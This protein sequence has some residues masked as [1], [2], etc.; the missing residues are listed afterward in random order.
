MMPHKIYAITR[1]EDAN[2]IPRYTAPQS[3]PVS[4][5][6]SPQTAFLMH[7]LLQSALRKGTGEHGIDHLNPD[8]STAGKTGTTYD[9]ADNWF[10]GYN[11]RV[12]CA[13]WAG[14][15]HGRRDAIYPAAFSR[16][17]VLP[18]W[19]ETM[20]AAHS[21][22]PGKLIQ[23]PEGIVKLDICKDSALRK[24]RYC[25]NYKR[26]VRTGI[27][28]YVSTAYTEYFLKG[29]APS[30]FCDVHGVS[31]PSLAQAD[32]NMGSSRNMTT[33]AIPVQPRAPTLL[34]NDPYG[35]EQP[36]F[37]PRDEVALRRNRTSL[38]FDQLES[39]DRAAAIVLDKPQ[40]VE[41]LED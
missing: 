11:S 19:V 28:S 23:A 16:E 37:A 17:T 35:T 4:R 22:F 6:V 8:P 36:D 12:T 26:N 24:T 1:I 39:E 18:V 32:L 29:A 27:E 13:V 3:S 34:G 14:F 15:L 5:V 25:Q 7:S 2:G 21:L 31:D 38:N 40:R 41:I 33:H 20:N 9:F 10:V 30:G